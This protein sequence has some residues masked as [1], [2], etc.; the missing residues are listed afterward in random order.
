MLALRSIAAGRNHP[1]DSLTPPNPWPGGW[2][3]KHAK[4]LRHNQDPADAAATDIL[5]TSSAVMALASSAGAVL[6]A[7]LLS[8]SL[9]VTVTRIM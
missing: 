7:A 9:P 1:R 3:W 6:A 2:N 4:N 8:L 5:P